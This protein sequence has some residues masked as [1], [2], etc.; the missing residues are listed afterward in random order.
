MTEHFYG[1]SIFISKEKATDFPPLAHYTKKCCGFFETDQAALAYPSME[2]TM[3]NRRRAS[4]GN[5]A[6]QIKTTK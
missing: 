5:S 4:D 1:Y 6:L 3:K 2:H